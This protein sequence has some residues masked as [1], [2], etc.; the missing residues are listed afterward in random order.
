MFDTA[1]LVGGDTVAIDY[2]AAFADRHVGTGKSVSAEGMSLSGDDA[3]NYVLALDSTLLAGLAA[4]I[5]A[6]ALTV[7]D[8]A[9]LGKTYDGTRGAALAFASGAGA[10]DDIAFRYEGLFDDRNA[11][12]G[13]AVTVTDGLVALTGTDAGNYV[14]VVDPAL[15]GGLTADIAKKSLVVTDVAGIAKT[16]DGSRSAELDFGTDDIV[17]GDDI[18]FDYEALAADRNVGTG[19]AVIVTGGAVA[20][21]GGDAANY[22]LVLDPGLLSGLSLDIAARTVT[23]GAV[24]A[25]DK[26]YDGTRT[27]SLAITWAGIV[28]G[29]DAAFGYDARF[30]DKNVGIG[31]PV[32]V[33]DG[34]G[35]NGA[36]AGNYVVAL[37]PALLGGLSAD[38]SAKTLGVADVLALGKTYDGSRS[39]ELA[40]VTDDIVDGDNV[41]FDYE[42]LFADRNAGAGKA[43]GVTG[44]AVALTGTDAGNYTLSLDAALLLGLGA[45]IG[46]RTLTVT[47]VA[48]ADKTYDGTRNVA[49]DFTA[50]DILA[51]DSVGFD[52][53]AL[54]ADRNAGTGKAVAVTGVSLSGEDAGNYDLALAGSL[55]GGLTVDVAAKSLTVVVDDRSRPRFL[56]NP[57]F[58]Y[59][60]VGLAEGDDAAV[61]SGVTFLTT[62]TDA[63]PVGQYAIAASGG[64]AP[65]YVLA[66]TPGTLTVTGHL[67][68]PYDQDR[69]VHVPG[70]LSGGDGFGGLVSIT[71]MLTLHTLAGYAE[72]SAAGDAALDG[73]GPFCSDPGNRGRGR[74]LFPHLQLNMSGRTLY[75]LGSPSRFAQ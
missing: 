39:A 5:T 35:L 40:F 14:L 56:P 46:R 57:A 36:D 43:V 2:S 32:T 31:K 12:T 48:A 19:K 33:A 72:G 7:S 41:A 24:A 22:D 11:G 68:P 55:L 60:L 9:A 16:Y 15:L 53:A 29:D 26:V 65:N 23:I 34:I 30:A 20:L 38:I 8:I 63:S 13:K 45:D 67:I 44:G 61:V 21:A 51:G 66:Y 52:Y 70:S 62:A 42:A 4:D 6:R 37:D 1:G 74:R 18:G 59:H 47:G 49:L 50:A 73:R 27:A 3:A 10:G 69:I 17:A 75:C 71:P 25:E 54:A 28:G 58:T 64:S